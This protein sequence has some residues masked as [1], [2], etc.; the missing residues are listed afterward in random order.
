MSKDIITTEHASL[1]SDYP[2][3]TAQ[4]AD[5]DN[6]HHRNRCVANQARLATRSFDIEEVVFEKGELF[7]RYNAFDTR[8]YL[9]KSGSVQVDYETVSGELA[10]GGFYYPMQV[11]CF[12]GQGNN[13][14]R[15][16][17]TALEKSRVCCMSLRRS[18]DAEPESFAKLIEVFRLV[19]LQK[20]RDRQFVATVIS[21]SAKAKVAAFLLY[22][23][24]LKNDTAI[25]GGEVILT[26]PR[27]SIS[28]F[29]GISIES[30]SRVLSV[31]SSEGVVE[32]F[33]RRVTIK[34]EAELEKIAY[35]D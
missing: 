19:A 2:D 13:L 27:S 3:K 29:L 12:D 26:M 1:S 7:P 35:F 9:L 10:V 15:D 34:K 4:R 5:C 18:G 21:K 32:V 8:L 28:G 11:F 31:L 30:V 14:L 24:E 33:N 16:R 25:A 23:K 17:I 20:G 6:C 22:V